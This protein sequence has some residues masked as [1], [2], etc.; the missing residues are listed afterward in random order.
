MRIISGKARGTKLSS[1]DG[2]ETRPTTDRIKE[3]LFNLLQLNFHD[4]SVLDLFSGSGALGLEAASRGAKKVLC[5]EMN[6]QAAM[7]IQQNIDKTRMGDCVKVVV[8]DAMNQ[9]KNLSEA[10]I[11]VVFMDPPY[12]KGIVIPM[13]ENLSEH[14]VMSEEGIVVIEHEKELMLPSTIGIF[15]M[16]KSRTYGITTISIYRKA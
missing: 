8:S 16:V 10:S 11:D 9:V 7:V 12:A 5:V 14:H 15:E 3:S 6:K 13:L 1:L 4:A 2:L